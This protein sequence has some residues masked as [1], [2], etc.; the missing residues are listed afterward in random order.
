MFQ[1]IRETEL[2][3]AKRKQSKIKMSSVELP[4]LTVDANGAPRAPLS[5]WDERIGP[6]PRAYLLACYFFSLADPGQ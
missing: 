3:K 2:V 1:P 6:I 4:S 5:K